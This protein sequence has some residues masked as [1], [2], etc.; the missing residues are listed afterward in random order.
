M[1]YIICC[2]CII[3]YILCT[4]GKPHIQRGAGE[5]SQYSLQYNSPLTMGAEFFQRKPEH[6]SVIVKP[7]D[8]PLMRKCLAGKITYIQPQTPDKNLSQLNSRK[9]DFLVTSE[10]DISPFLQNTADVR[11]ICGLHSPVVSIL[12]PDRSNIHDLMEIFNTPNITIAIKNIQ[13]RRCLYDILTAY[14]GA[15]NIK[16]VV[17]S[18]ENILSN[19]GTEYDMYFDVTVHPNPFFRK[20][21]EK[22]PSHMITMN[23]IN[24]GDYFVRPTEMPFYRKYPYYKKHLIDKVTLTKAYLQISPPIANGVDSLHVPTIKSH[25]ILLTHKDVSNSTIQE[26]LRKVIFQLHS[27]P[28]FKGLTPAD[29]GYTGLKKIRYHSGTN[30][31]YRQLQLLSTG[32]DPNYYKGPL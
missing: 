23:K 20:L 11:F 19:Y 25:L 28:L 14:D 6:C 7:I 27:N 21:T 31:I 22:I 13:S 15:H 1:L 4:S 9:V 18:E 16:I 5:A 26:V 30:K 10:Y 24:G 32:D 2:L 3:A 8:V 17:Q 12:A 29:I